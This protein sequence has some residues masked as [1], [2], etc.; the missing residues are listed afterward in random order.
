MMNSNETNQNIT[1]TNSVFT[2][3]DVLNR[4]ITL[5]LDTF[6]KHIAGES[7][8]HP[9]RHYL[10]INSNVVRIRKIVENPSTIIIDKDYPN[11]NN[12]FGVTALDSYSSLKN[13]KIVTE[14]VGV[15]QHEIV[16]IIPQNRVSEQSIEGRVIYDAY[17]DE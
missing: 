3:T 11:R 2:T 13:V 1:I 8:D 12:Y 6:E 10:A 9:D 5:K 7:G 15:N 14:E 4:E 16:T 17:S